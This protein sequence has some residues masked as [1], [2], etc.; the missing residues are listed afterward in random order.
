MAVQTQKNIPMEMRDG[1]ILRADIN[2]PDVGGKHPAVLIRTPYGKHINPISFPTDIGYAVVIQ[3]IRGRFA[4]EGEWKRDAIFAVEGIDGYD[5]VEWIAA[6]SWCDG[7]IGMAG[8]SYLASLQWITAVENPPHLK[9]LSPWMGGL[10]SVGSGMSPV[11]SNGAISLAVTMARILNN[12]VDMIDKLEKAGH[13]VSEMRQ[14]LEWA[15][16]KQ[17]EAINFLPLKSLPFLKFEPMQ[18][19]WNI[20][21]QTPPDDILKKYHRHDKI[22][23]PCFQSFGWYDILEYT[24]LQ[25]YIKMREQGASDLAKDGQYLIAGPWTHGQPIGYLGDI[26]FGPYAGPPD[27]YA[28]IMQ[29]GQQKAFF[30]KYLRGENINIPKIRYFVMGRNIWQTADDWPLPETKWQRFYLHSKGNAATS[31]GD[32]TL[33]IQPPASEHPDSYIYNPLNPSPSLGGRILGSCIV[34]G[35]VEQYHVEK[36]NDVLC[37]STGE[38]NDAVEITGPIQVHLFAS[39]SSANTDFTAKLCDVYPDGRSYNLLEGI[40]R[41]NGMSQNY[42][43]VSEY[44]ITLGDTSNLF[45]K[46]HR[47]RIQI[48]SS[49]FPLYDRNM[50]T[51]NPIGEDSKGVPVLQT[52]YH[53]TDCPSYIDLP[54]IN[55]KK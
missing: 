23:V 34:P 2:I 5:S 22:T 35:P 10:G 46:G 16:N 48:S 25:S 45:F 40:F 28:L 26:N 38:L 36:R 42:G 12:T 32:G 29:G 17:M 13:N 53:Q 33:T 31:A 43:Q 9:A 41:T 18:E 6:Q 7:N 39:S 49:N 20:S 1:T 51:G 27:P 21:L 19:I 54:V 11:N 24:S 8:A 15:R 47:I 4:S 50:N 52:I 30:D 3:D 55:R 37:Y 14:S 44:V